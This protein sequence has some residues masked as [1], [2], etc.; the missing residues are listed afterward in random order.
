MCNLHHEELQEGAIRRG[1]LGG[2]IIPGG[3]S[4]A[5]GTNDKNEQLTDIQTF[6]SWRIQMRKKLV[7]M[8]LMLISMILIMQGTVFGVLCEV[9]TNTMHKSRMA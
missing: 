4:N 1:F 9:C 6:N 2:R 5:E 3:E 7:L 8:M